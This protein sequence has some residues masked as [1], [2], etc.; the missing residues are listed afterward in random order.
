MRERGGRGGERR[1]EA[2]RGGRRR[3]AGRGERRER[4]L[5][6][7]LP[8][9]HPAGP[10]PFFPSLLRSAPSLPPLS[11]FRVHH[12]VVGC[13][14]K[15][16]ISRFMFF[17]E[18]GNGTTQTLGDGHISP[19]LISLQNNKGDGQCC[20]SDFHPR[21]LLPRRRHARTAASPLL[22]RGYRD[23]YATLS[24]PF[25]RLLMFLSRRRSK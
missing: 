14:C 16:R 23:T 7:P 24:S 20:Q 1:R 17:S 6:F 5:P 18:R 13:S 19:D 21:A 15:G 9:S 25:F 12:S 11:P 4:E 22:P 10:L 3:E 8:L 2:G